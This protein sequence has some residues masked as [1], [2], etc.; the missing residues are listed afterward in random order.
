MY[1]VTPSG[2]IFVTLDIGHFFKNLTRNSK[3][4]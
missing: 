4:G 1:Q 3:F 2:Q